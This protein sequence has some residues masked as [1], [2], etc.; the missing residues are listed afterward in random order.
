MGLWDSIII[1]LVFSFVVIGLDEW[2]H[3]RRRDRRPPEK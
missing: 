3:K 1:C 2:M